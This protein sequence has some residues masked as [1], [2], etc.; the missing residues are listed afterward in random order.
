MRLL[1]GTAA[2]LA[3]PVAASAVTGYGL[4]T[5][6]SDL[7]PGGETGMYFSC[8]CIGASRAFVVN[9]SPPDPAGGATFF[10]PRADCPLFAHVSEDRGDW[11]D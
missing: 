10:E 6:Q 11:R 4:C 9:Y 7:R 1:G 2:L 5:T 3:I 8:T